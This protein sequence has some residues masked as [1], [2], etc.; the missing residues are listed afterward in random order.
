[1]VSII[2]NL[3]QHQ[4]MDGH[5]HGMQMILVVKAKAGK[6]S[7][8]QHLFGWRSRKALEQ[9]PVIAAHHMMLPGLYTVS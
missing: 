9:E 7:I 3:R 4:H 5:K 8:V 6:H 2:S 1:M